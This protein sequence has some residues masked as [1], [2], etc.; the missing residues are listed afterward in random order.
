MERDL[1]TDVPLSLT[2]ACRTQGQIKT[3]SLFPCRY[4]HL[5]SNNHLETV[6]SEMVKHDSF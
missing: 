4:F 3:F 6:E 1:L 5:I 2:A